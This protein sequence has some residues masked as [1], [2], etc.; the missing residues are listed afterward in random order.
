MFSKFRMIPYF[1]NVLL[2][3]TT[4]VLGPFELGGETLTRSEI[5]DYLISELEALLEI[6][7]SN[8][9]RNQFRPEIVGLI[10][11]VQLMMSEYYITRYSSV[12]G[13]PVFPEH[14]FPTRPFCS[15]GRPKPSHCLQ[16]HHRRINRTTRTP[17]LPATKWRYR[18]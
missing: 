12:I 14:H 6:C 16:R 9:V 17:L 10:E 11:E 18:Y 3:L 5:G 4:N 7:N 2:I 8:S 15:S 1:E 13:H